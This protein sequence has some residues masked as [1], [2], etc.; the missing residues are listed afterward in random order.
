MPDDLAGHALVIG[1]GRVGLELSKI[2]IKRGV[3]MLVV[4]EDADRVARAR[5]D[6]LLAVRGNANSTAV[7]EEARARQASLAIVAVPQALEAAEIVTHLK[8]LSPTITVL[9]RAHSEQGVALMLERGADAA[10]LAERELAY[11]L[12]EMVM[13][14]PPYR[15]LRVEASASP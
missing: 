1:Y 15:A 5:A 4:E 6:G 12:A 10:V 3:A 13:A 14:T 9:A 8:K 11:A 7:L 2:L